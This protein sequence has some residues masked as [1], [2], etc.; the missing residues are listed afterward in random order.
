AAGGNIGIG[1]AIPSN[2]AHEVME[3]IVEYGEVRRGRLGIVIQ[4]VTPGLASA[5]DL[6]VTEGAL[7]TQVEPGTPAEQAGIMAGDVVVEVSGEAIVSSSDL[8]NEIG[9]MRVDEEVTLTL[10]RGGQTQTVTATIAE[11]PDTAT[12]EAPSSSPGGTPSLAA[13][14][15]AE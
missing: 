15:G 7:V 12:G 5:L 10:L 6:G 3:Q 9:L 1:F 13:L 8:R 14:E 4:D 2:M 11:A